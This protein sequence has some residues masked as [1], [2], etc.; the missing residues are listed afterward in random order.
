MK[1]E[2]PEWRPKA[3]VLDDVKRYFL[4]FHRNKREIYVRRKQIAERLKMRI[5][6]LDRY[7]H[8]LAATGWMETVRRTPRTAIRQVKP[9]AIG[10]SFGGSVGGS[11]EKEILG[12]KEQ[13]QH[14]Q[15]GDDVASNRPYLTASGDET[16]L[17]AFAGVPHSASN[18]A[19]IRART[20]AGVPIGQIRGAVAMALRRRVQAGN[21]APIHSMKY[22]AGAIDE[23][24]RFFGAGGGIDYCRFHEMR[25]KDDIRRQEGRDA[26]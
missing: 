2:L 5:R 16:E 18:V 26:A 21:H 3:K 13:K 25:L 11:Q 8:H 10:A 14:H 17:L 7:L 1:K 12:R 22:F 24:V 15:C 19:F 9:A 4:G 6:T 23:I 20:A